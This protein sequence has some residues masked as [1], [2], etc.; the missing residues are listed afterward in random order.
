MI[1]QNYLFI[2]K[3]KASSRNCKAVNTA[4]VGTIQNIPYN[5]DE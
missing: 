5:F 1:I 3:K 2:W 4:I